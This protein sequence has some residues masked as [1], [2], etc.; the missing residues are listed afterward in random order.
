LLDV[1][2]TANGRIPVIMQERL[3]QIGEWLN[4]NGEAIYGTDPWRVLSEGNTIRYTSKKDTVY[5]ICLE[6][7]GRNL[8]LNNPRPA[9]KTVVT[10]L[11][12]NQPLEWKMSEGKMKIEV[13]LLS[14]EEMPCSFA[15]VFK[16][17]PV[18]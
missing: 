2:P 18:D 15:Y 10:L 14:V 1:G 5:A 7:P 9:E 13:P 3:L 12:I 4:V 11:G 17:T 8:L 6:W 16:L